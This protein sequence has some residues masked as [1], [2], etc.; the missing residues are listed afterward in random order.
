MCYSIG[1]VD[2]IP[3]VH[4]TISKTRRKRGRLCQ[5]NTRHKSL[6]PAGSSTTQELVR[7]RIP[8]ENPESFPF[9]Q[10]GWRRIKLLGFLLCHCS[11]LS[12][13]LPLNSQTYRGSRRCRYDGILQL[14]NWQASRWISALYPAGCASL[15]ALRPASIG[16]FDDCWN[17]CH[18]H[19][20]AGPHIKWTTRYELIPEMTHS[21]KPV[22]KREPTICL[23]IAQNVTDLP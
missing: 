23:Y 10:F 12:G 18:C 11:T 8:D 15:G 16:R 14:Q 9:S 2:I 21:Y 5:S 4:P 20:L 17:R 22:D 3:S 6:T 1:D 13:T 7:F 19:L